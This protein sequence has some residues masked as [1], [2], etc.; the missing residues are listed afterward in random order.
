MVQ[1]LV[2]VLLSVRFAR[3]DTIPPP[4][5][6][7]AGTGIYPKPKSEVRR[8]AA[9]KAASLQPPLRPIPESCTLGRKVRYQEWDL[10]PT[11]TGMGAVPPSQTSLGITCPP[12]SAWPWPGFCHDTAAQN[13][14][15]LSG[16]VVDSMFL[17]CSLPHTTLLPLHFRPFCTPA[18]PCMSSAR[19]WAR[20]HMP[21]WQHCCW[22]WSGESA[23]LCG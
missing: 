5:P 11:M 9:V 22:G 20:R 6:I 16:R 23:R 12:L 4:N 1:C 7:V 8:V 10:E 17:L 2:H 15:R 14:T 19:R 18:L 21:V 3:Q 13:P